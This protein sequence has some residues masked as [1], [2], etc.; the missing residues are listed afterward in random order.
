MR[1]LLVGVL[2][3]AG[4]GAA[5]LAP[6][7]PPDA[8]EATYRPVSSS[9][10]VC[11]P[12]T[13][14]GDATNILGAI[15]AGPA[16]GP[17]SAALWPLASNDFGVQLPAPGEPVVLR[18]VGR[19]Q[20]A[21]RMR[22]EGSWAPSAVAGVVARQQA[23]TS[24]GLS[25]AACAVPGRQWW[26]VGAGSQLGRGAA[27]L[28][29]NAAEEPARFDITLYSG[30]GPVQALAG[31]GIDLGPSSS[32][33]LRLDAL[34]PDEELLAIQVLATSGRVAAA[35]RDVAVPSE[36][37]PRG[38]DF[39][40]PAQAPATR[41]VIAGIPAGDGDRDLV[42]VN[43]GSQFATVSPRL[44]TESGP[45][46]LEG[47]AAVAVP[48]G[49][50]IRVDL[51]RVLAGRSGTLDLTSDVPV[52]GGARAVWGGGARRDVMWLAAVPLIGGP[53]PLGG[54]AAVPSG[55]GMTTTVTVGAPDGDVRGTLTIT[56]IE[57][58]DLAA[59]S[60]AAAGSSGA[61]P[62]GSVG[63]VGD[64]SEGSGASLPELVLPPD[65]AT[66]QA[67]PVTVPAGSQSVITV[68]GGGRRAAPG[69]TSLSWRSDPGSGPA[70]VSHVALA[71]G[72]PLVTGYPWW[73]V[74]SSVIA[75][76]VREDLGILAP[77]G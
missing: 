56:R 5:A 19:S 61:G 22:A 49:A 25:S 62:E 17:G 74:A 31:K 15:V 66:T 64:R 75:L 6:Q 53:D 72:V 8:R 29:S 68:P 39:I 21:I 27:L 48:A 40:P 63:G 35:V 41:L 30:A 77:A 24:E 4:V 71:D 55:P 13:G 42:L 44:L 70:A 32:V 58:D 12:M 47:L 57:A 2:A 65:P 10:L 20:P 54:A 52:T 23:G 16:P 60:G 69:L 7:A 50:I 67:L 59:L 73:P 45:V 46:P 1:R 18:S 36:D 26:F 9:V 33:R 37:R 51:N 38:V 28:V 11:P 3:A 34:A 76:S 14:A 43:P